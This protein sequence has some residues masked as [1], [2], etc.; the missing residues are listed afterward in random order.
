LLIINYLT[1]NGI[2]IPRP[3]CFSS[4][5]LYT[6]SMK[7]HTSPRMKAILADPFLKAQFSQGLAQQAGMS[8]EE[9]KK[10]PVIIRDR[11]GREVYRGHLDYVH[12]ER[13]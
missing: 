1:A 7:A 8:L 4:K 11:E 3:L 13:F 6:Q 2:I 9:C 5:I 10:H 12:P